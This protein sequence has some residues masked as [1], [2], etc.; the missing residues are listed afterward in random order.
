[1]NIYENKVFSE[2]PE[3]DMWRELLQFTYEANIIRYLEKRG[4]CKNVDVVNCIAGSF[5]QAHEYYMSAKEADLQISP[6]LLYYGTTNLLYG[7]ANLFSGT[8]NVISN[9]G[10]K[11]F[12]PEGNK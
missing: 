4:C 6:L 10:M 8:K 5:L 3:K 11:I 9:H 1:M 2:N 12:I 7:M